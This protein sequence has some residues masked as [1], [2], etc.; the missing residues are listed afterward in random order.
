MNF[1]I[2]S[3]R[4]EKRKDNEIGTEEQSGETNKLIELEYVLNKLKKFT[5]KNSSFSYICC[6]ALPE[7][8]LQL[9]ETRNIGSFESPLRLVNPA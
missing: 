3:K 4:A 7:L 2:H 5:S 6:R 8:S 1:V 9:F